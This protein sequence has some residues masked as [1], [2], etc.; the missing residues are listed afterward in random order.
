MIYGYVNIVSILHTMNH[1]MRQRDSDKESNQKGHTKGMRNIVD[2]NLMVGGV[3]GYFH[4]VG[5]AVGDNN[6]SRERLEINWG[7]SSLRESCIVF[8]SEI[9]NAACS[10]PEFIL[11]GSKLFTQFSILLEQTVW[12]QQFIVTICNSSSSS[13]LFPLIRSL[14]S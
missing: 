7:V 10:I 9:I 5:V 11:C 1:A 8:S 4:G 12:R 2:N 14:G 13:K 6:Y 3:S